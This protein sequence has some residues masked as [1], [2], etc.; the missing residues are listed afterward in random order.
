[1]H[2]HRAKKCHVKYNIIAL[3]RCYLYR[4]FSL[5]FQSP[6]AEYVESYNADN[7]D[8][9]HAARYGGY[10]APCN[11]STQ[12]ATPR[13]TSTQF[14]TPHDTSAQFA[15]LCDTPAP[16]LSPHETPAPFAAPRDTS[17]AYEP[18]P[19]KQQHWNDHNREYADSEPPPRYFA[20]HFELIDLLPAFTHSQYS[21]SQLTF[22]V[23]VTELVITQY[24]LGGGLSA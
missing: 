21:F 19:Y 7:A 3:L 24:S 20:I 1:M 4:P 10:V 23:T 18:L 14:T 15:T 16:F 8:E 12:F 5:I 13:D 22:L 9:L 11:T 2:Q 6:P 17:A